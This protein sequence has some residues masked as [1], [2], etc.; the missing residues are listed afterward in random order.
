MSQEYKQQFIEFCLKHEVIRFGEFTLKSGRI[1]PYFFNAGLFNTGAKIA[2]LGKFY[3]AAIQASG[4]EF[5]TLFGPAYKGIPLVTTTAIA[6]QQ[7]YGIDKPFCFNRT[8]AK[9]HGEGGNI[10]GAPLQGRV[11]VVDD[12]ITAGTA[13]NLAAELIK[14]NKAKLGGVCVALNRQE[15]GQGEIS[16]IQEIEQEYDVSVI[17]VIN[18]DDLITYVQTNSEFELYLGKIQVYRDTYG[19]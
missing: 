5:D 15:K 4:I 16:A 2:Q 6:L 3:A 12:V 18:L 14:T 1:S 17:S 7:E 9:D 10:V 13:I 11:L 19:V 8:I